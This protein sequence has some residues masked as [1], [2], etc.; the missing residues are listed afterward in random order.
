MPPGHDEAGSAV[1]VPPDVVV[2]PVVVLLPPP[3]PPQPAATS[4]KA[5]VT[6]IRA[7]IE[8]LFLTLPPLR[9]WADEP[10]SRGV[11]AALRSMG[12]E[13]GGFKRDRAQISPSLGSRPC[14]PCSSWCRSR[15]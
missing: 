9:S 12:V 1:A 11:H 6:P 4:A 8:I 2:D 3:P 10:A 7:T 14:G 15:S 13:S 5:P